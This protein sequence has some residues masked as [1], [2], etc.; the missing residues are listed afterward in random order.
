MMGKLYYEF[1]V[2]CCVSENEPLL[3]MIKIVLFYAFHCAFAGQKTRQMDWPA[4]SKICHKNKSILAVNL[5]HANNR[6]R[7][8]MDSFSKRLKKFL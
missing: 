3:P 1:E 2:H 5:H 7:L 8:S 6:F 4:Q